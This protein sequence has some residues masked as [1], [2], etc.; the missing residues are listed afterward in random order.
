MPPTRHRARVHRDFRDGLLS[1]FIR[2]SVQS[3]GCA[4][5]HFLK[6]ST[7]E[8]KWVLRQSQG[9]G[10]HLAFLGTPLG[11]SASL[12]VAAICVTGW[13]S[14]VAQLFPATCFWGLSARGHGHEACLH[15]AADL[16]GLPQITCKWCMFCCQYF[17]VRSHHTKLHFF[18]WW[19]IRKPSDKDTETHRPAMSH[20]PGDRSWGHGALVCPR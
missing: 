9:C 17:K 8:R 16:F 19:I 14:Q 4:G 1:S 7:R 13:P 5:S 2:G 15:L 6:V 18:S 20:D 11:G 3:S 12:W 10:P